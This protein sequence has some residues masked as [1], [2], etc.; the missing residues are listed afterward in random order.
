MAQE[1]LSPYCHD[2]ITK[3]RWF[4]ENP[5]KEERELLDG[6]GA[7][8][9]RHTKNVVGRDGLVVDPE[10]CQ[11]GRSCFREWGSPREVATEG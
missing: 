6:S 9:C 10:D 1:A 3:K 11:S 5:P 4:L 8:W 7:C 2:L